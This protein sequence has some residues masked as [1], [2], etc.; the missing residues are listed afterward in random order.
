M[1][2][3]EMPLSALFEQARRLHL[4]A[5]DSRADQDVVKEGCEM[6]HKCEDM[7]GKLGLFSS[8]ETKGRHQHQQS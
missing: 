6:L 2:M 8:N 7:V 5:S 4:K 1:A 3:E